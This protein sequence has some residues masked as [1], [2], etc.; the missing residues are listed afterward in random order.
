MYRNKFNFRCL[1]VNFKPEI[2]EILSLFA[3]FEDDDA[4][5]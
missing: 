1:N 5:V 3:I 4:T 2:A